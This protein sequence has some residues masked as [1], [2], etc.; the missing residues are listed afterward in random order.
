M[1]E[2]W[3]NFDAAILPLTGVEICALAI[4][5]VDNYQLSFDDF[6]GQILNYINP[7]ESINLTTNSNVLLYDGAGSSLILDG[8]GN[9]L[10]QTAAGA[11]QFNLTVF[12]EVYMQSGFGSNMYFGPEGTRLQDNNSGNVFQTDGAGNLT[13]DNQPVIPGTFS[14]TLAAAISGGKLVSNGLIQA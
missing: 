14:G 12:G 10:L 13:F 4:A 1:N 6:V 3:S 7:V 5:G 2:K 8:T 11:S 9:V